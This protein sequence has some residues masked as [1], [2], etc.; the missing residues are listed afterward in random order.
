VK[1]WKSPARA[2]SPAQPVE[3]LLP[4]VATVDM[5]APNAARCS[6]FLRRVA[7][8]REHVPRDDVHRNITRA[9]AKVANGG[10]GQHKAMDTAW[11]ATDT[12]Q[13]TAKQERR[14]AMAWLPTRHHHLRPTQA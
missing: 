5:G 4:R 1:A 14:E 8:I 3:Y 12:Q 6:K 2:V 9:R 7:S 11:A 13:V 10:T